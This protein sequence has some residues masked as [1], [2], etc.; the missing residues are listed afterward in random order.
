MFPKIAVVSKAI[1]SLF[2]AN[3]EIYVYQKTM[4]TETHETTMHKVNIGKAACR[5][6]VESA[7]AAN[8]EGVA[9]AGVSQ[10]ITLIMEPDISVP[11]GACVDITFGDGTVRR[12][13]AAGVTAKYV[14]HQ[15]IA[16]EL[17]EEHP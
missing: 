17:R 8:A 15:E 4:D 13:I 11:E 9:P 2:D 3:C 5:V 14:Y 16:L 1:A 12:Y 7:P 6:N 10:L